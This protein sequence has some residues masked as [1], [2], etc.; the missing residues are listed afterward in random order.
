MSAAV[1]VPV[2]EA[3]D[4]RDEPLELARL[5]R[6]FAPLLAAALVCA[7]AASLVAPYPV[8]IFHDDGVYL[9]LA[10]SLAGGHGYRYLHL[11]GAP[12][13]THYPPAYPLLLA[14]LWTLAPRFPANLT[15]FLLANAALLGLVAWGTARY[16]IARLDWPSFGATGF[17]LVAT[18]SLPLIQ[19]TT[20]VMSEVLFLALLVPLLAQAERAVA[21]PRDTLHDVG[22]GAAAGALTLARVH[23]V[24][25][26]AALV[27]ILATRRDF[28]RTGL[29]LVGAALVLL[30]WQLWVALHDAAL[31]AT[32]RGSYGSY[33]TWFA[34]GVASG[35]PTFVVRTIARNAGEA[36][37]IL[38]DRF[39]PWSLGVLRLV[40]LS[41]TIG[42]LVFG[43]LCLR[44]RAPVTMAFLAGYLAVML[45]WPYTPWRFLWGIWPLLLLL[46]AEG[47]MTVVRGRPSGAPTRL[48]RYATFAV[49]AVL[50]LGLARAEIVAYRDRAWTA[51]VRDATQ[52]IA[53]VMRWISQNTRPHEVVITD[54]EPLVYLFTE[55]TALPPVAFTAAEYVAPRN[56]ASDVA[57]LAELVRQF[58]VRYVVTVV[59]STMAAARALAVPAPARSVTLRE[60]EATPGAAVFEVVRRSI[61]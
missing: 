30:P 44:R 24:V 49:L 45:I 47:A 41:L 8:G 39:A 56:P 61:Q 57:A 48:V 29:V 28:R 15:I 53:P 27:L 26:V 38:A 35:G 52:S 10:K 1:S 34:D 50:G 19:L 4:A 55:R 37:A 3:D 14:F 60:V 22:L 9:V 33:L 16:L 46:A 31:P 23:G 7:V 5:L 54:A 11:P 36:A 13:A 6:A 58:P 20:L 40:P 42:L 59:P 25:L 17:A 51:P 12:I 21:T 18:L 32:I 43:G 2:P